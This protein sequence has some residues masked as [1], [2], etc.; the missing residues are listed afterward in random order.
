MKQHLKRLVSAA[1]HR[2]GLLGRLQ[3]TYLARRGR[4]HDAQWAYARAVRLV[5]DSDESWAA[6]GRFL[7]V[8]GGLPLKIAALQDGLGRGAGRL[9]Q[10][11]LL[12]SLVRAGRA[13]E[14]SALIERV[15][16]PDAA[17]G[18]AVAA[19]DAG[20]PAE[21]ERLA[22]VASALA[23]RRADTWFQ[24][25][26]IHARLGRYDD[27]LAA[28]EEA[29]A[30]DPANLTA[31]ATLGQVLAH[32][33]RFADSARVFQG[34]LRRDPSNE[35]G[36]AAVVHLARQQTGSRN[37]GEIARQVASYLDGAGEADGAGTANPAAP[38]RQPEP[39]LRLAPGLL[40]MLPRGERI[41]VL[42]GGARDAHAD[43]RWRE[44][45]ADRLSFHGFEPDPPEC[46]RLN[47]TLR[48]LGYQGA[49]YPVGLWKDDGR[50]P[51]H[52][53]KA[54]GGSSFLDQNTKVTDRWRFE[55]P[56]QTSLAREIFRPERTVDMPVTSIAR[57]AASAGVPAIDFCKLN[58]QGAEL[59]ILAAAGPCLDGMLGVLAETAFVES[60]L[61][62]P[63]FS[64]IDAFLRRAGFTFF[65]LV[66]HHYVGRAAAPVV[67]QH[68]PGFVGRLGQ[69]V[70]SW[71]QLIE[72]HSLYLRDPVDADG[73][74]GLTALDTNQTIKLA[75]IAE[76]FGQVEFAF[77][78]SQWLAARLRAAGD[79]AQAAALTAAVDTAAALY[80]GDA[81][82]VRGSSTF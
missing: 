70:S 71:G 58:V 35:G 15:S 77:E 81:A 51:F 6:L 52:V 48:D 53:N 45:P 72:G 59:D 12:G 5:P 40:A 27:A 11:E 9:A 56:H 8:H 22:R 16:D 26:S 46:E 17:L 54:S 24:L 31:R 60:Y 1:R 63:F 68:L 4:F 44:L 36:W 55:N 79:Q 21:A 47:R 38:T 25:G 30:L 19:V 65:D 2:F 41:V 42:D 32:L 28:F 82:P 75:V 18:A 73:S 20:H 67:V 57:W 78:V 13:A 29:I 33:G 76:V 43:P 61:A 62:R 34:L 10:T 74:S 7:E 66:A 23:P 14:L 69:L 3:A 39:R 80:R 49:Y 37:I 50:L 64:D